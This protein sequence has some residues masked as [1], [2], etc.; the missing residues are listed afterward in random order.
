MN[1]RGIGPRYL[2]LSGCR[3]RDEAA[4]RFRA[5]LGEIVGDTERR[6]HTDLLTADQSFGADVDGV[7]EALGAARETNVLAVEEAVMAF[8]RWICAYEAWCG[9][10]EI[11][12]QDPTKE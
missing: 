8:E 1:V 4:E 2:S 6:L 5:W 12:N 3:T 10:P 11:A 9:V 7:D